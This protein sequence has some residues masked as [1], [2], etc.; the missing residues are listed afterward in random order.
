MPLDGYDV[1]CVS[2]L[3]MSPLRIAVVA[4][5]SVTFAACTGQIS[6]GGVDGGVDGVDGG[7]GGNGDGDG[8]K[9]Q[10]LVQERCVNCHAASPIN[11]APMSLA[12][13]GS[14]R[15]QSQKEPSQSVAQR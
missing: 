8:C 12:S 5:F 14:L 4:V 9:V 1:L 2:S 7:D 3:F 6:G 13:L 10:A 11:G 15:L